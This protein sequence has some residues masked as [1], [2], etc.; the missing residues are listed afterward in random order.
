[1]KRR[2]LSITIL[3]CVA[4]ALAWVGLREIQSQK[5]IGRALRALQAA[6]CEEALESSQRS[7]H[8]AWWRRRELGMAAMVHFDCQSD[9]EASLVV[10]ERALAMHPN[11]INLLLTTGARRLKAN[12]PSDAESAFLHCLEISPKLG[13]GWLGLAMT[14]AARGDHA[15]AAGDC[16]QAISFA[17]D[18]LPA[19]EFC[20]GNGYISH[21]NEGDRRF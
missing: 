2:W 10:L 18:F 8:V 15:T 17:P 19:R 13:R 4:A 5:A 14:R 6:N 12:R 9:P 7:I 20:V 3:L 11:H 1:V 16:R 21:A